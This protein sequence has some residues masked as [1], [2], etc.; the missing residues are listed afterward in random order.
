MLAICSE[1]L[2]DICIK[3]CL[4][5]HLG[6]S[7]ALLHPAQLSALLCRKAGRMLFSELAEVGT[8]CTKMSL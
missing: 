1:G 7:H 2:I 3:D 4:L 6:K 5:K 8:T